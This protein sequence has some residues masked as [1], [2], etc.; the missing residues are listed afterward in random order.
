[1]KL[2]KNLT[3][4]LKKREEV[5][6]IKLSLKENFPKELFDLTEVEEVYLDGSCVSFPDDISGWENLK[7]LSVK[8]E[9]FK[10]DISPLFTLPG[11]ENLK[12]IE[13]P[14]SSFR[15]PLGNVAA[16]LK[17]L[18]I[19]GCGLKTLPEEISMLTQLS[20][21]HLPNN[22]LTTLPFSFRELKNLKRLNLDSNH[23][24]VFPDFIKKMPQLGHLSIDNNSFSEDEKDRIQREFHI[25]PN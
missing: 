4:A 2:Y 18:S 10:G 9:N 6:A 13:T 3:S 5:R 16:P 19:K 25:W 12:I 11:L 7:I 22:E 14:I 23:F 1:M 24:S 15:L 8:W 17:F 21:F 20:E